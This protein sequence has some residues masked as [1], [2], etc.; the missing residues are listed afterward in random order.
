MQAEIRNWRG[1]GS[2]HKP[3]REAG[4]QREAPKWGRKQRHR[5][6]ASLHGHCGRAESGRK[7]A[8]RSSRGALSRALIAGRRARRSIGKA[9]LLRLIGLFRKRKVTGRSAAGSSG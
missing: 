3:V 4:L 9:E 6:K 1:A 2:R 7:P 5:G 8:A